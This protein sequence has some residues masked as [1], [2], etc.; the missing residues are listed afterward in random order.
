MTK[1]SDSEESSAST[2]GSDS[3]HL[4][5]EASTDQSE[6][7]IEQGGGDSF[8]GMSPLVQAAVVKL[9]QEVKESFSGPL[10]HPD[11]LKNYEE[12][13][14]GLADRIVKMAEIQVQHNIDASKAQQKDDNGYRRRGMNFGMFALILMIAL[15]AYCVFEGER[16]IAGIVF[17]GGLMWTIVHLFIENKNS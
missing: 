6:D 4:P 1:K 14:P 9:S 5:S 11:H 17:G 15:A 13:Q 3:N 7:D 10:P 16:V 8:E 2:D 12:I